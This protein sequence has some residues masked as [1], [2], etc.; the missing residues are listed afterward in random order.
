MDIHNRQCSAM[1]RG[2]LL[3]IERRQLEKVINSQQGKGGEKGGE[4]GRPMI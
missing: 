3:V 4:G 2:W 1:I